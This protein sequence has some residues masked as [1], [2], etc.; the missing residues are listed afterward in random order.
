MLGGNVL[1]FFKF[2]AL[3]SSILSGTPKKFFLSF[4][5]GSYLSTFKTYLFFQV[6]FGKKRMQG[7]LL[8]DFC[9][10]YVLK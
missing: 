8:I 3:F 5:P 2:L 4:S 10:D 9:I 7:I 1:T 6:W